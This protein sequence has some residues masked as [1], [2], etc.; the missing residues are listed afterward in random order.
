[1]G[2][3]P[4]G[5]A[6]LRRASTGPGNLH[7]A[8]AQQDTLTEVTDAM[9]VAC[10]FL[11][12]AVTAAEEQWHQVRVEAIKKV[13]PSDYRGLQERTWRDIPAE[14]LAE[15]LCKGEICPR[16]EWVPGKALQVMRSSWHCGWYSWPRDSG[17][18]AQWPFRA[19]SM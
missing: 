16:D 6:I 14:E 13:G 11:V 5:N 2:R 3:K 9:S 17:V 15:R 10:L 12:T 8:N 19:S 4:Q 18:K 7:P 1:M